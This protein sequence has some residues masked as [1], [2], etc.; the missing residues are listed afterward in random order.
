[1]PHTP[2]TEPGREAR[3][4]LLSIAKTAFAKKGF[5]DASLNEILVE[6]K[7]SKGVYY[8][9]FQDKEDLF[10]A[11]LEQEIDGLLAAHPSPSFQGVEPGDFWAVATETL[12]TWSETVARSTDLALLVRHVTIVRRRSPKFSSI[13]SKGEGI[14]RAVIEAGQ[15]LGQ[16]RTDLP[17][18]V[19]VRLIAAA[20]HALDEGFFASGELSAVSLRAHALLLVDTYRRLISIAP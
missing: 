4:R 2:Q 20:D 6:A 3:T 5:D 8:Y 19:L 12:G 14:L 16:V 15:R 1:M 10:A 7:V 11:V 18:D 17:A 9:Y 13:L